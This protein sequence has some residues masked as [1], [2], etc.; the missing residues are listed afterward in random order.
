MRSLIGKVIEIKNQDLNNIS[1]GA[2]NDS[3][4]SVVL[5]NETKNFTVERQKQATFNIINPR[6]VIFMGSDG[7]GDATTRAERREEELERRRRRRSA[8]GILPVSGGAAGGGGGG[9][10]TGDDKDD[11][12]PSVLQNILA[13]TAGAIASKIPF[14]T[15]LKKIAVPITA[16]V[17]FLGRSIS[18]GLSSVLRPRRGAEGAIRGS[19][20]FAQSMVGPQ[21][22]MRSFR[23]QP[24]PS[25]GSSA[26][27]TSGGSASSIA[28]RNTGLRGA[29]GVGGRVFMRA[30]G[31]ISLAYEVYNA[32]S[33]IQQFRKTTDAL[34]EES[35]KNLA[36]QATA[37]PKIGIMDVYKGQPARK[38]HEDM[39]IQLQ[40]LGPGLFQQA[41]AELEANGD[42][43]A[44]T[45][46]EREWLASL[47][48]EARFKNPTLGD[49]ATFDANTISDLAAMH[50]KA[51]TE[52]EADKIIPDPKELIQRVR[53]AMQVTPEVRQG[54]E[55]FLEGVF[56]RAKRAIHTVMGTNVDDLGMA[57]ATRGPDL[58]VH[59]PS[60]NPVTG[61]RGDS[62]E[63]IQK[64]MLEF[65]A[66]SR[67]PEFRRSPLPPMT[68]DSEVLNTRE[69]DIDVVDQ[70]IRTNHGNIDFS[71]S[72]YVD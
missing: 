8:T 30:L 32:I 29:A 24:K 68:D 63:Q 36:R 7:D 47:G 25:I 27:R 49:V 58:E 56:N 31:P 72:M 17:A 35:R 5:F 38:Y 62:D 59:T 28:V 39:A 51:A 50:R 48:K 4:P 69:P 67:G 46:T 61:R 9:A 10:G 15:L 16:S 66:L 52:P 55:G 19:S 64:D 33:A 44:K 45:F 1:D 42:P 43:R 12:V 26:Y 21:T 20:R 41:K 65:L 14:L 11:D 71:K 13:G 60:V 40:E 22:G 6:Q 53:A 57:G 18:S 37:E 23:L 34:T 54:P 3:T 2:V 70:T